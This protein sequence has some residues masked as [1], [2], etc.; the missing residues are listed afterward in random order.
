MRGIEVF[1]DANRA[2]DCLDVCQ[3]RDV[4]RQ[5]ELDQILT[6]YHDGVASVQLDAGPAAALEAASFD[7]G[8]W[9]ELAPVAR[10]TGTKTLERIGQTG[11]TIARTTRSRARVFFG[12][13]QG[14]SETEEPE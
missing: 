3:L 11:Q 14:E 6:S 1:D 5:V 7:I 9:A 8:S 4:S 12:R 13:V 10:A 2:R